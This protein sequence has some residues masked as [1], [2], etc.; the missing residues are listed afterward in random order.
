MENTTNF[1]NINN[2]NYKKKREQRIIPIYSKSL[3]T[4]YSN[5]Y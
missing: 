4:Q 5:T 1:K 2:N 3:I